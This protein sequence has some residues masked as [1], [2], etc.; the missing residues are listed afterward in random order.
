[1]VAASQRQSSDWIEARADGKKVRRLETDVIKDFIAYAKH[2]GSCNADRYYMI[3]SKM[4]ADKMFESGGSSW[5]NKK[6]IMTAFQLNDAATAERVI[7]RGLLEGMALG[8]PYKE[9]YRDVRDRVG[10][11]SDVLGKSLLA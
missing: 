2:Q 5:R 11:L 1:M 6:D 7:Q 8:L 3:L 10:A 9:I 4:M